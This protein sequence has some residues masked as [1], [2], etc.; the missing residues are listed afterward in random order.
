M[1]MK[2]Y[3]NKESIQ[4]SEAESELPFC[5]EIFKIYIRI[6]LTR[7][8]HQPETVSYEVLSYT[9]TQFVY[10]VTPKINITNIDT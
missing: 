6:Y 8:T 5:N 9:I 7:V 10:K 2:K 3:F 1:I 4:Y